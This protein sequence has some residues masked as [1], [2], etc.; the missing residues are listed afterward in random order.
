MAVCAAELTTHMLYPHSD[1]FQREAVIKGA[2]SLFQTLAVS[3]PAS[4][5]TPVQISQT[6]A[7]ADLSRLPSHAG[8]ELGLSGPSGQGSAPP[9]PA[10]TRAARRRESSSTDS[11]VGDGSPALGHE[12]GNVA[13]PSSSASAQGDVEAAHDGGTE[14]HLLPQEHVVPLVHRR[15]N[16][17]KKGPDIYRAVLEV[18]Y[19]GE[20]PHLNGF[21]SVLTTPDARSQ[22][23][24]LVESSELIE[25]PDSDT[26]ICK[27]NFRLGW[28]ASP[29]DAITVS[30][31]LDDGNT[32]IDVSASL[33]ASPDA[34]AYLRPAPPYVR[35]H[36]HLFA[37]SVQLPS[38][39]T[40][41]ADGAARTAFSKSKLPTIKVTV[42]WSWDLK[43]ARVG[44]LS[45]GVGNQLQ[46]ALRRMVS[47]VSKNSHTIPSVRSFG[48]GIDIEH[49]SFDY[50]RDTLAV[51]Y[52]VFADEFSSQSNQQQQSGQASAEEQGRAPRALD[53]DL[54]MQD[55]WDV[56]I[57]VRSGNAGASTVSDDWKALPTCTKGIRRTLLRIFHNQLPTPE[58]VARVSIIAQ[59]VAVS[60]ELRINGEV[61]QVQTREGEL[62]GSPSDVERKILDDAASISGI[63]IASAGSQ[64]TTSSTTTTAPDS[65]SRAA[66]TTSAIES[67]I[68]RNYIYFTSLLQEPEAKWKRVSDWRGV[69]ITQLD[70]IDPTLVV[71]RAEATF[72]G[73]GIWDLYSII[74]TTAA[75][76][77][78][79]KGL[80]ESHLLKDI[81]DLSSLWWNKTKAVWPV[82]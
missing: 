33:R 56:K 23:D 45:G 74:N 34:P 80:E 24:T 64:L 72:V 68:R 22:W 51:D 38:S 19:E 77:H 40:S 71:Y 26:R 18:P 73:V 20:K 41:K 52:S 81:N 42:F 37:W 15:S 66:S 65:N 13:F 35:S 4:S 5:W 10:R 29:R 32:L 14:F 21:R 1:R 6:A 70:S 12:N 55:G 8:A 16:P 59:R 54:P 69:T 49:T 61:T 47:Y 36:V 17:N 11:V 75:R 39:A 27:T 50:T 63:S 58:D 79:D 2:I 48:P 43:G 76:Q 78:W 28:P 3:S 60:T 53:L 44:L 9:T 82:R 31:T 57:K 30:R 7:S 25:M 62:H 67:L 46:L